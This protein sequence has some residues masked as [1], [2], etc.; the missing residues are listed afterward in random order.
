MKSIEPKIVHMR[1]KYIGRIVVVYEVDPVIWLPDTRVFAED[2]FGNILE[3]DDIISL[4]N[5]LS[6]REGFNITVHDH[7]SA[8]YYL[9]NMFGIVIKKSSV[10]NK[11]MTLS[12]FLRKFLEVKEVDKLII[13]PKSHITGNLYDDSYEVTIVF[14]N[15]YLKAEKSGRF[16]VPAEIGYSQKYTTFN[17]D[18]ERYLAKLEYRGRDWYFA[19]VCSITKT[20][21]ILTK[22]GE[23]WRCWRARPVPLE[24]YESDSYSGR[25]QGKVTDIIL[26]L[27]Y[28]SLTNYSGITRIYSINKEVAKVVID[29]ICEVFNIN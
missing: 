12:E 2:E 10:L 8:Y 6:K 27:R 23:K 17:V 4:A 26:E 25:K 1:S 9:Q 3:F 19:L 13:V 16:S 5:W 14:E 18:P 22:D 7:Y 24:Y 28:R 21:A 15:G 29:K 11:I 20:I